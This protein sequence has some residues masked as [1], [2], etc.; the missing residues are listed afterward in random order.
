MNIPFYT[1]VYHNHRTCKCNDPKINVVYAFDT[2]KTTNIVDVT[3]E[4]R[5][6][7]QLK[8]T[9]LEETTDKQIPCYQVVVF[10]PSYIKN[11]N[12][13]C[14]NEYDESTTQQTFLPIDVY[15]DYEQ[16]EYD[17]C[18]VQKEF[19]RLVK[20]Y[21][22][23]IEAE[24]CD[25]S[26]MSVY[27]ERINYTMTQPKCCGTCKWCRPHK[28]H[29]C[30][31]TCNDKLM[32]ECHNPQNQ[33]VFSCMTQCD[34]IKYAHNHPYRYDKPSAWKQMPWQDPHNKQHYRHENMPLNRVFPK[35]NVFG[36][37][38]NY[39]ICLRDDDKHC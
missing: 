16:F 14:N 31:S 13:S 35:V 37:C 11:A 17:Y 10:R 29:H 22:T 26:D 6:I 32:F 1:E 4:L 27:R 20:K 19:D 33:Q 24:M 15:P 38:D 18:V 7:V 21:S 12:A 34:N 36:L 30:N 9:F 23:L 3:G 8:T 28:K 39:C 5:Y 25:F 2:E